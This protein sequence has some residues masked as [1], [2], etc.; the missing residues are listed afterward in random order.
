[1]LR[2]PHPICNTHLF[3]N[4]VQ[5]SSG[6]FISRAKI[7]ACWLEYFILT[8]MCGSHKP[9][10]VKVWL[11]RKCRIY[12]PLYACDWRVEACDAVLLFSVFPPLLTSVL[13]C[14]LHSSFIIHPSFAHIYTSGHF[15]ALS[16]S[17]LSPPHLCFLLGLSN[18]LRLPPLPFFL[19][20]LP[21]GQS[22]RCAPGSCWSDSAPH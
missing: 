22:E 17:L 15:S 1:M 10:N 4:S 13:H 21:L 18:C 8:L 19:F 7:G 20:L 2:C 16:L 9:Q 3:S 14:S 11:F 12:K 6:C 5:F